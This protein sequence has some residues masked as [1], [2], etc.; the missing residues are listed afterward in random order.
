MMMSYSH[1][2]LCG[3][4]RM[5]SP[6]T[7]SYVT[8]SNPL[9]D[10]MAEMLLPLDMLSLDDPFAFAFKSRNNVHIYLSDELIFGRNPM[11]YPFN[12]FS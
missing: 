2:V 10:T 4:C 12:F 8:F 5:P 3:V 7:T 6:Q 1:G 11:V 9:P